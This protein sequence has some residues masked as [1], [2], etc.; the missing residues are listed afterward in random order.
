MCATLSFYHYIMPS[1]LDETR[2]V[3]DYTKL[4]YHI[5]QKFKPNNSYEL[6][7]FVQIGYMGLLKAIKKYDKTKAKFSTIA[8]YY[9]KWEIIRYLSKKKVDLV[10]YD[11]DSFCDSEAYDAESLQDFIPFN[12]TQEQQT[13][14]QLRL[15]GFTMKQIAAK[16]NISNYSLKLKFKKLVKS[17][18]EEKTHL[19]GNR[20]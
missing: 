13:I 9:I 5:A 18:N 10:Y 7:D 20:S 19:N 2:I 14:L 17:F 11:G 15:D 6:E 3:E 16:L 4:V 1:T 8:W 12:L